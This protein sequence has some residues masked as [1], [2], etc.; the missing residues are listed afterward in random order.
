MWRLM[1]RDQLLEVIDM[2]LSLCVEVL[3]QHRILLL[4]C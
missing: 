2:R 1:K 4:E 3:I